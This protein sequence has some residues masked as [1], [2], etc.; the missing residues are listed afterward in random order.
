MNI[1][2]RVPL[3]EELFKIVFVNNSKI[4]THNNRCNTSLIY[5][6]LEVLLFLFLT[7]IGLDFHMTNNYVVLSFSLCLMLTL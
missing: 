4:V 3:F 5:Y 2:G 1:P 7:K 6:T